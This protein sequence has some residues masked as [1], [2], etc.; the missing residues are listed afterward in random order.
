VIGVLSGGAAD[1]FVL[2]ETAFR[3]GL[4]ETGFVEGKNVAFEYRW[5]QGRFERLPALALD[6]VG[7]QPAVIATVTLPAALAAKAAS[8]AIP[9]VFVI[10][11][12]PVKV[13]LVASFSRPGGNVTGMTNFMN[14]LANPSVRSLPIAFLARPPFGLSAGSI[15]PSSR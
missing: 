1:S 2:L 4:N 9:V 7:R 5:A 11:E 13:G 14:V 3:K 12:D 6:L 8:S 15:A 10:G